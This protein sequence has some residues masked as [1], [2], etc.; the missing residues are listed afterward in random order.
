[1]KLSIITINFNNREGLRKT[2]ESVV[3]QTFKDFEWIVIDG[4]ST[5]GSRELIV[6]YSDHFVY[7]V[8]EPDKGIYHAMNKGIKVANGDY[9]FFLNSGD[10]F[11]DNQVL[12]NVFSR[13]TQA[14]IVIGNY[15]RSTGEL[16]NAIGELWN[17]VKE[18]ITLFTFFDYTIQHSGC[19]FIKRCLFDEYGLYDEKLK[20]NSDWKWFLQAIGLGKASLEKIEI[21]ISVYDIT[22]V[23]SMQ[24]EERRKEHDLVINEI[25][26]PRIVQDHEKYNRLLELM[27]EQQLKAR[28]SWTYRIGHM[29]TAPV[30]YIY[31]L[32][33]K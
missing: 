28:S 12:D 29:V 23:S 31:K 13:K 16:L 21:P 8:S 3:P 6:Q 19:A 7:W 4:G 1:M 14:D 10:W 9:V 22:G 20:I 5:D 24:V 11:C 15:Y 33:K 25:V 18:E 17:G 32:I 30:K 2:I 26:P 27:R